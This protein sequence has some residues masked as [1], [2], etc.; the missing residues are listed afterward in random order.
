MIRLDGLIG[1]GTIMRYLK[2]IYLTKDRPENVFNFLLNCFAVVAKQYNQTSF[3]LLPWRHRTRLQAV[4]LMSRII[5]STS[6][7]IH[8]RKP[9]NSESQDSGR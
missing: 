2:K 7:S 8:F 5:S 9:G 4:G 1:I 3:L 6:V